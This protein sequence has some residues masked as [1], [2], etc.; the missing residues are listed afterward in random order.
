MTRIPDTSRTAN[1]GQRTV[2]ARF[3]RLGWGTEDNS[4]HDFG[5]DLFL[6][7]VDETGLSIGT[8]T[9]QVKSGESYFERPAEAGWWYREN[10]KKHLRYW[11][12]QGVPHFLVM[13]SPRQDKAYWTEVTYA[14]VEDVGKGWKV[15]VP[16][17]NVLDESA[18][19]GLLTAFSRA[20]ALLGFEGG[21]WHPESVPSDDLDT[22]IRWALM[23]PRLVA[24]HENRGFRDEVDAAA[25]L[26][27]LMLGRFRQYSHFARERGD[28]PT[29]QEAEDHNDWYW[30]LAWAASQWLELGNNTGLVALSETR[31]LRRRVPASILAACA[32]EEGDEPT[33]ALTLLRERLPESTIRRLDRLDKGWVTC[34]LGRLESSFGNTKRAV[35]YLERAEGVLL[36]S[37]DDLARGVLAASSGNMWRT[38]RAWTNVGLADLIQ[39][40]DSRLF[41]WR[42]VS[43]ASDLADQIDEEFERWRGRVDLSPGVDSDLYRTPQWLQAFITGDESPTLGWLANEARR[44]AMGHDSKRWQASLAMSRRSGSVE[45]Q[46]TIAQQTWA[47]GPIDPLATECLA[48]LD[49]DWTRTTSLTSLNLWRIAPDLLGARARQATQICLESLRD[50]DSR[51][52]R[53]IPRGRSAFREIGSALSSLLRYA[54]VD[55]TQ[56]ASQIISARL[57]QELNALDALTISE[58]AGGITWKRVPQALVVEIVQALLSSGEP[59]VGLAATIHMNTEETA[60]F[61]DLLRLHLLESAKAGDRMAMV[62]L[63]EGPTPLSAD[64]E[65]TLGQVL[66]HQLEELIESARRQTYLLGGPSV[67]GLRTRLNCLS[68][69]SANWDHVTGL[70]LEPMASPEDKQ[71]VLANLLDQYDELPAVT[72]AKLEAPVRRSVARGSSLSPAALSAFNANRTRLLL[73]SH[74]IHPNEAHESVMSFA[75]SDEIPDQLAASLILR[76]NATDATLALVVLS[77]LLRS[78]RARVRVNAMNSLATRLDSFSE[79]QQKIAESEIHRV[80]SGGGVGVALAFLSGI[81]AGRNPQVGLQLVPKTSFLRNRSIRVRSRYRRLVGQV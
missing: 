79:A 44:V 55:Q 42:S 76:E 1:S 30:R 54:T 71:D 22:R 52:A 57:S 74:S 37:N 35:A 16:A 64:E 34:H 7:A 14:N 58:I 38:Q 51:L 41:W 23:A 6:L 56:Q 66:D 27:M 46:T 9:A 43:A 28:V 68:P 17:S 25:G 32:L 77:Q 36:P 40:I 70:L 59:E 73:R 5:I 12:S 21:T 29:L 20:S 75:L 8:G 10:H 72:I 33:A 18:L 61:Q 15:L 80:L 19:P 50:P 39:R 69:T 48:V 53:L 3:E 47:I 63:I 31:L 4:L 78:D 13:Y 81:E 2:E 26:A 65:R 45:V 60:A 24:P 62:A 11:R 49:L 67:G